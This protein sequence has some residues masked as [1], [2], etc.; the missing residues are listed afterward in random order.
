MHCL[1]CTKTVWHLINYVWY[2]C[3]LSS[4]RIII[5]TTLWFAW[6]QREGV[7]SYSHFSECNLRF[8]LQIVISFMTWSS[9]LNTFNS[10]LLASSY[11]LV[12]IHISVTCRQ[13]IHV[14]HLPSRLVVEV[15]IDIWFVFITISCLVQ[16]TGTQVEEFSQNKIDTQPSLIKN[17]RI[18]FTD[19]N[20]LFDV[21]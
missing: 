8:I 21:V 16:S 1:W 19:H 20:L 17:N 2:I 3:E 6:Q 13:S 7:A 18:I 9:Q 11:Y 10:H 14:H 5:T 15:S 4:W 12:I